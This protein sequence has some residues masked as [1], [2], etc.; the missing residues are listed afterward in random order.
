MDYASLL[1]SSGVNKYHQS[2]NVAKRSYSNYAED[3]ELAKDVE[4]DV[5]NDVWS[6]NALFAL[7]TPQVA[8]FRQTNDVEARN[9]RS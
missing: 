8:P 1:P 4:D 5:D 2:D 7:E 9:K 3:L 6:N